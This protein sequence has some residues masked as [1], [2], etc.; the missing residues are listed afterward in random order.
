MSARVCVSATHRRA[1]VEFLWIVI[2]IF[3][4][5]L[6]EMF[7]ILC[8]PDSGDHLL[9]ERQSIFVYQHLYQVHCCLSQF[10]I[11]VCVFKHFLS[12][13]VRFTLSA[14]RCALS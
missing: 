6:C 8:L 11:R 14:A 2:S 5:Y 1:F 7:T 12:A 10:R 13:P 9:N 3:L 4:I